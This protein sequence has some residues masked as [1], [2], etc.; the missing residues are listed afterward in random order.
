MGTAV[1]DKEGKTLG[2]RLDDSNLAI[3]FG[4]N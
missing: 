4:F 2:K 3:R 1:C